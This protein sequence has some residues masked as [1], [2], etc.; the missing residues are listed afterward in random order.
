M[1]LRV[2]AD[3][4]LDRVR[5][6][7]ANGG[8]ARGKRLSAVSRARETE[9]HHSHELGLPIGAGLEENLFQVSARG[10]EPH[11]HALGRFRKAKAVQQMLHESGLRRR[12][13]IHSADRDEKLL[14][15]LLGI[16]KMN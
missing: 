8:R 10:L 2:R 4:A 12:E 9:Q 15:V 3:A 5:P 6:L 13:A 11:P 7:P 1:Y 14:H 16:E